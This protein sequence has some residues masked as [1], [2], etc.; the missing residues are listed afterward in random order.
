MGTYVSNGQ[1]YATTADLAN[2]VAAAALAHPSTGTS[3]QNAQLLKAS[4]DIDSYL[5]DQFELP[6][7]EWGADIVQRCCDIAAYRLV[8]LRGF[9]PEADGHFQSN[10]KMA[11]DWLRDVASG[12]VVPD[13]VDSS[14]G[15][16]PGQ[17]SNDA[18]PEVVTASPVNCDTG[19]ATRG[20]NF[21]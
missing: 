7:L 19:N 17:P 11:V 14:P 2:T 3:A 8:C 4:E 13:V 21:R 18:Q 10:S 9:N 5:R 12:K 6:L 16:S 15:A 1:Q 20:S